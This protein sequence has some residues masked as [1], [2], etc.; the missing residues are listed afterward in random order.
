M[1]VASYKSRRCDCAACKPFACSTI[2]GYP[3][4]ARR[5]QAGFAPFCSVQY[6]LAC[7]PIALV[8]VYSQLRPK[9]LSSRTRAVLLLRALLGS[10]QPCRARLD[11]NTVATC[12]RLRVTL[13]PARKK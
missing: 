6:L 7:V 1:R 8:V 5:L 3:T 10:E 11:C 12:T 13:E 9:V 4:I 2:Y